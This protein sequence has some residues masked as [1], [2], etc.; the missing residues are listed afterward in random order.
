MLT[1]VTVFR[2]D[3]DSEGERSKREV[4]A[5]AVA[6]II[7]RFSDWIRTGQRSILPRGGQEI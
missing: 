7:G 4:E 3:V 5:E 2:F 6:Y 1:L